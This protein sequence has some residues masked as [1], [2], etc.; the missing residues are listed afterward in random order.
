VPDHDGNYYL[1]R[2][3][4]LPEGVLK[5]VQAKELL[6]RGEAKSIHDAVEKVGLSRSA[7][8]KYKDG[9]FT[10]SMMGRERIVTI[11]MD[12][13]H[14]SGILS[15]V[16]ALIASHDGNVLTINQTIPL[17]GMANVTLSVD[18]SAMGSGVDAMV[19]ALLA[20][21]GVRRAGILG[22][23]GSI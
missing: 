19:G 8:Y 20:L 5:T 18:A 1:I 6:N 17:Q 2:E 7:F 15:K 12:L 14:K 4:L 11:G 22:Q 23:G 3:D 13:E 16:L 21:D 10:L 9:V